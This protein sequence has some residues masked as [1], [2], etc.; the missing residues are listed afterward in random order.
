MTASSDAPV[1]DLVESAEAERV[2]EGLLD[3]ARGAQLPLEIGTLTDEELVAYLGSEEAAGPMGLWYRALKI[4]AKELAQVATL[5]ALTARGQFAQLVDAEDQH[6]YQLA[7]PALATLRLRRAEPRLTAQTTRDDGPWW[8]ILRPLEDGL[9]LREMV[10]PAGMHS[11]HL[12]R[13]EDEEQLFLTVI[14]V[15]PEAPAAAVEADLPPDELE[16]QSEANAFLEGCTHVTS[17]MAATPDQSTPDVLNI[18]VK[19]DEVF[20]GRRVGD[21]MAFRGAPGELVADTWRS[22]VADQ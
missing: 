14:G 12:V 5:R 10:T 8:Y 21:H 15:A 20:L 9:W 22:W 11:F 4:E 7:E 3:S 13:V 2:A 6:A 18:H 17:L 19:D 1:L 16:E